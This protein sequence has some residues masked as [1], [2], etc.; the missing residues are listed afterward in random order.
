M[1]ASLMMKAI[2]VRQS[3]G[4]EINDECAYAAD[5]N[6]VSDQYNFA[7]IRA[8]LFERLLVIV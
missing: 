8:P 5:M 7:A 3:E 4:I 1:H 2:I 6:R